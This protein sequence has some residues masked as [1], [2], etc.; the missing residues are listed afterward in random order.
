MRAAAPETPCLAFLEA[1]PVAERWQRARDWIARAPRPFF[2]QL[3]ARRTALD[4]GAAILVAGRA[5]VEEILSLPQ[6]FSVA[7]YKPKMGEFMLALDGTE[8]NYRDKAV[9]RAVLSWRDLPA[10]RDLAGAETDAALDAGLDLGLDQ[11]GG[12]I[13][14]VASVS[15]RVPLRIVQRFF[16][17]A[18][19][20]ADLLR[21]SYANQFDQFNNLSF[22]ERPDADAIHAAAD[23]ARQEMRAA[24]ARIIPA[25]VA[26]IEAGAD[27]PDDVLTR[28]LRLHLPAATG[29]GMDRVVINVGG[30]LIGAIETTS[31][32]VVHALAEL[33]GRPQILAAARAAARTG[34]AAFDGYVWEALRFAPIVAF[35]FRQA[36]TDHVLGRGSPA[37]SRIAKGRVVLPL[38]LSAMFDATGVPDP[39]RFDPA[40]P[41]QTYLHFGRGH[42]ECLGRYVAGAMVPEIVRRILLRDAVR[43]EGAVEDGGTPFPTAFRIS[44]AGRPAGDAGPG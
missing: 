29:F 26:A 7:L 36:E 23:L 5:E 13:D 11:G 10:I 2:A 9:M 31:E 22:D 43:A 27:L 14:V 38:S 42:H 40:R 20:D 18:A 12:S 37:E 33:L 21:W 44:C 1:L 41:E 16:G 4:C 8:V 35:M 28:L 34:P 19:P 32:A 3:R 39:D 25:R 15:R 24:F 6:V 30:L 17:F